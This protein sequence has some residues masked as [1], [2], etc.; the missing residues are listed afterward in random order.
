VA[1]L[2]RN[3]SGAGNVS[4]RN[5]RGEKEKK[6][7]PEEFYSLRLHDGKDWR[8]Q[9]QASKEQLDMGREKEK[10]RVLDDETVGEKGGRPAPLAGRCTRKGEKYRPF[11]E[12]VISGPEKSEGIS[13]QK[14]KKKKKSSTVMGPAAHWGRGSQEHHSV[15][16]K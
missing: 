9:I 15:F 3:K 6:E 11:L 5:G 4:D 12:S 14:K 1:S 16:A 7:N 13:S 8:P 10:A 2:L